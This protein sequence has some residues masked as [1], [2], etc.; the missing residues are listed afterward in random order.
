VRWSRSQSAGERP[1]TD[2]P[3]VEDV[4][5]ELR[6]Y[7]DILR[8]VEEA[9]AGTQTS[10]IDWRL[11]DTR[12]S[13]PL[14]FDFEPF[15]KHYATNIDQRVAIVLTETST[16]LVPLQSR[17]ERPRHFTNPVMRKALR[18]LQRV[19]NDLSLSEV[20]FGGTLPAVR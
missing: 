13:S 20:D 7:L 11:A 16:G 10:A 1:D 2:A 3:T 15:P 4:L 5:D 19:T 12:H 6:D 9:V 18:V 8:G 14:A 17:A